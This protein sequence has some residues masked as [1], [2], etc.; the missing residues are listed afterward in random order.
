VQQVVRLA[1]I[2]AF[3]GLAGV[4]GYVAAERVGFIEALYFTLATITTVGYGDLVPQTG[5]GRA[6]AMILMLGGVATALYVF[7][8]V[9][10]FVVEGR[11]RQVMGVRKMK[12][13]IE[14]V[15]GHYVV[16]GFGKLGKLVARELA[17]ARVDFVIVESDPEK[18]AEAREKE[19]LV[20]EG[21]ATHQE[22]LTAAGIER[23]GGLATTISDDA[24]NL[25]IGIA[26]RSMRPD[27]P[28]VCRSS[29][30]RVRGLFE[31]AGI[32]RTIS[33][34]E[35][36]ARRVV[37]SLIRPHVVEFMDELL[38]PVENTPS[39]HGLRLEA[40]AP[41]A[42]QT[43]KDARLRN[44][45]DV[46][47]L[48]IQRDGVFL[49]SPGPAEQLQGGDLLILLGLPEKVEQLRGLLEARAVGAPADRE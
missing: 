45:F 30:N 33:T 8:S 22:V 4:L 23:A 5:A 39:L 9:S 49:P 36:G 21:D 43:L 15:R 28:V 10:A 29:T 25:Y 44:K 24:E 6:V 3:V 40:G 11:L 32:P 41:L 35:I 48:A 46:V 2:V 18:T 38:A 12:R 19:Y 42:G 1:C 47:V 13:T 27:L 16:C 7:S 14:R 17:L 26:A 37:S 20:I 31:R 34:D